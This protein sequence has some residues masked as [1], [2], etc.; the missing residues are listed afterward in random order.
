MVRFGIYLGALGCQKVIKMLSKTDAKTDI[1]K[2]RFR[3]RPTAKDPSELVARRGLRGVRKFVKKEEKKKGRNLKGNFEDLKKVL[4]A[5]TRRV[6]GLLSPLPPP[7]R[8]LA[9]NILF[10]SELD[11]QV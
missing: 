3:G 7:A 10:N 8:I 9:A 2:S 11:D 5:L 6:G 1:G 4:H